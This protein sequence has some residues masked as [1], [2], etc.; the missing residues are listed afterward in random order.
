[1]YEY[2]LQRIRSAELIRRADRERTAREAVRRAR[3]ARREA[4]ERAAVG[5]ADTRRPRRHRFPR[6]A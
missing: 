1:M 2:E 6:T 5:G 4:A 3:A